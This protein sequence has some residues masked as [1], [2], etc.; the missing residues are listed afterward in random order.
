MYSFIM[1]PLSFI[2]NMAP[3]AVEPTL[4]QL[5]A[6]KEDKHKFNLFAT[7]KIKMTRI[8]VFHN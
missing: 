1:L 2:V 7:L 5:P 3:L 6:Y 8:R 4:I